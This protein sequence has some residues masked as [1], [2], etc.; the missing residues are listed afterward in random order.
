[1]TPIISQHP[2][3]VNSKYLQKLY[4]SLIIVNKYLHKGDPNPEHLRVCYRQTLYV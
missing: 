3:E 1:M 2:Q 4:R